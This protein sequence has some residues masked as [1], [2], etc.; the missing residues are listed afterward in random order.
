MSRLLGCATI[1]AMVLPNSIRDCLINAMVLPNSIRD[2]LNRLVMGRFAGSGKLKSFCGRMAQQSGASG[3]AHV[4]AL[5]GR[6]D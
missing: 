3:V 1:N 2:C 4:L 6:N 5:V